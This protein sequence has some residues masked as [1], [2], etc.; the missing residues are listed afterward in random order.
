MTQYYYIKGGDALHPTPQGKRSIRKVVQYGVHL[1]TWQAYSVFGAKAAN[2]QEPMVQ[3][4]EAKARRG[5]G[6]IKKDARPR[7]GKGK[8]G[9]RIFLTESRSMKSAKKVVTSE[10]ADD[11][12][13]VCY[14]GLCKHLSDV[15]EKAHKSAER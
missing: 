6:R 14:Q 10:R 4:E 12:K 15:Q 1:Y 11:F 9:A 5:T 13:N 8:R 7:G 3:L 2:A